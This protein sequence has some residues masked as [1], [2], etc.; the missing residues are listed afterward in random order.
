MRVSIIRG[1][2]GG[3]GFPGGSVVKNL[4]ANAG[5][6]G[7]VLGSG[8][9]PGEGNSNPFQYSC[10]GDLMHK[11]P[12]GLPPIG[13]CRVGHALV[14]TQQQQHMRLQS[15]LE[16]MLLLENTVLLERKH[17]SIKSML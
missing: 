14:T 11:E 4:P 10:L 1:G 3:G 7:S 16:A 6:T 5:D 8:R 17:F 12:G 15:R 2:A 13:S 9:S